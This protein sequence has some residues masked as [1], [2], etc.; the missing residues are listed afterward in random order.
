MMLANLDLWLPM[1][2][3]VMGRADGVCVGRVVGLRFGGRVLADG[4]GRSWLTKQRASQ[5]LAEAL[6]IY[7]HTTG[8]QWDE[9]RTP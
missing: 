7:T 4:A 6:P 3:S 1:V 9:E 2:T 8:T 5:G